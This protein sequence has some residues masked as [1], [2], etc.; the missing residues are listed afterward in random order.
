MSSLHDLQSHKY[1]AHVMLIP[2]RCDTIDYTLEPWSFIITL[3]CEGA[4]FQL[5][6]SPQSL[7]PI[8][9]EAASPRSLMYSSRFNLEH[10]LGFAK[11][12]HFSSESVDIQI[13][14]QTHLPSFLLW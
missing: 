8:L 13:D 6:F 11:K 2:L 10:N 12:H 5:E 9:E 14:N 3:S 1:I 7:M 4:A